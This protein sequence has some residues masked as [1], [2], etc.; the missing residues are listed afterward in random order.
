MNEWGYG[1]IALLPIIIPATLLIGFQYSAKQVMPVT[2]AITVLLALLVWN[3]TPQSITVSLVQGLTKAVSI[4][5]MIFGAIFLLNALKQTGAIHIIRQ[6]FTEV[7]SDRRI[8]VIIIAWCFGIFIESISNFGTSA[9]IVAPL[10]IVLGFPPLAAVIMAILVQ[11]ASTSLSIMNSPII[12]DT[13]NKLYSNT[14]ET[15]FINEPN[16]WEH[17]LALITSDTMITYTIVSSFIPFFMVIMLTRFF[18]LN[19]SWKEGFSALPFALFAGLTFTIPHAITDTLLGDKYSSLLGGLMS[20]CIV[21]FATKRKFLLPKVI[22]RFPCETLWETHWLGT[23]NVE[24]KYILSGRISKLCAWSPYILISLMLL[25]FHG[26]IKLNHPFI[27]INF[28]SVSILEKIENNY[29]ITSLYLFGSLLI[30]AA[31]FAA[32]SQCRYIERFKIIK[33]AGKDSFKMMLGASFVLIFTLPIITIY[34]N[35]NINL[36]YIS[37]VPIASPTLVTHVFSSMVSSI[38]ALINPLIATSNTASEIIF[39]PAQF[40]N[41]KYSLMPSPMVAVIQTI[42]TAAR[43]MITIQNIVAVSATVGVFGQEATI[44]RK[45]IIPTIC[46]ITIT[47]ITAMF[48][49][50]GLDFND[51]LLR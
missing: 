41:E 37:N 36:T 48:I 34:I 46:Y 25:F 29:Q 5:W 7:T 17:F 15:T 8:Q 47:S 16:P 43:S 22:W 1:L 39:S 12:I 13:K 24:K 30:T 44:L 14:I 9:V 33:N 28:L 31:L 4:L 26:L 38:N 50:Y 23:L 51:P 40:S 35:S 42:E 21:V 10:L 20:I 45:T 6:S 2:L 11:I 27:N 32:I 3:T 19:K 49:L 18:G